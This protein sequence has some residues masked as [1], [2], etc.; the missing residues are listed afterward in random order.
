MS[1]RKAELY[2]IL[3]SIEMKLDLLIPRHTNLYYYKRCTQNNTEK[4]F[5]RGFAKEW[6]G[7][8]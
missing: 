1:E 6:F 2:F 4:S 5:S 3:D 7:A 8:F